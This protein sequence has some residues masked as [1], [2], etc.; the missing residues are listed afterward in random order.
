MVLRRLRD[1]EGSGTEG[2]KG[3]V[4]VRWTCLSMYGMI[5]DKG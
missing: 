4:R 5:V 2:R 1:D 3:R